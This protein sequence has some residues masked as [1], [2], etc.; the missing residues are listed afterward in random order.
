MLKA[1]ETAVGAGSLI[2]LFH[3]ATGPPALSGERHV[4]FANHTRQAIVEIHVSNVGAGNWQA[5]VLGSDFLEPG[6]SVLVDIDVRGG[7]CRVDIKTVRDDGSTLVT[8]S[9]DICRA[10]DHAVSLR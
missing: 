2:L 9:V 5:D 8:P 3:G 4:L 6:G 7:Q 10:E 1:I